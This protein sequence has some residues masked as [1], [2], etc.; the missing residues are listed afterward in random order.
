MRIIRF[1]ILTLVAF[2]TTLCFG[3]DPDAPLITYLSVNPNNQ[4]VD[5][6][7]VNSSSQ[8]VG[9]V[10]YFQDISGLW[11]PLDTVQ[12]INNTSYTTQNA[13]PQQKIETFSVV[14]FDALGNSSIRS[15]SHSTV[16]MNFSFE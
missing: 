6:F 1:V 11:I 7:W 15:D 13:N 9:Y 14:A 4:Q 8:V 10:I 2:N 3:Q 12:G 16:F 5:I